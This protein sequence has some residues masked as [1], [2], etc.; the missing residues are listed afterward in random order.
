MQHFTKKLWSSVS[1][2]VLVTM[3]VAAVSSA[4]TV[5]SAN[6]YLTSLQASAAADHEVVFTTPSGVIE[7]ETV[8]LTFASAF[9]TSSITEDDVD[10]LDEAIELTTAADCSGSE[11]ASVVMA[12]DMLT[13][14]ICVGDGG[15]IAA[16]SEVTIRIGTN[17][18]SSG[19]GSNQITNPTSVGTYYVNVSGSFGDSGSIALPMLDA[20]SMTVTGR[21]TE[22]SG[23]GGG[24]GGGGASGCGD[25]TAP[26]ISSIVVSG[27][28]ADS[29]TVG[30]KSSENASGS[31]DYGTTS[32]YEIG[33]DEDT[34]LVT[35][36]SMELSSLSEGATYHFRVRSSDLCGNE[37]I[38]SD[39][40]FDTLDETAPEISD[41]DVSLSCDTTA[42]VSWSTDED[43]NST[44]SYGRTST[45]G[46]TKEDV[47][48]E[49][50]HSLV[51]SGLTRDATYHFQITSD[52]ES[53]NAAQTSDATFSADSDTAPSNVSGF[54][55]TAGDGT[56]ALSWTNPTTDVSGVRILACTGGYPDD[57]SDT[58][59]DVAYDGSGES[60]SHSGLSNGTTYYYG[61]FAY[62]TCGQFASGALGQGTPSAPEEEVL[63]IEEETPPVVTSPEETPAETG[64]EEGSA[65]EGVADASE[66]VPAGEESSEEVVA[67]VEIPEITVGDEER[68]PQGDMQFFVANRQIRL[69]TASSGAVGMLSSRPLR[70]EL[71]TEHISK[72]V[73]RVQLV[74]GESAYLMAL[75]SDESAY[76]TDISSPGSSGTYATA[77]SIYYADGT[78]QS[79][80]TITD[81]EPDG[82][83]FAVSDGQSRRVGGATISLSVN[84]AVTWDGSPYGQ[85][86][87]I[88]TESIGQL[89][90]YV[91]NTTYV[92][93]AAADG[94]I[95]AKTGTFSVTNNIANPVIQLEPTP[96]EVVPPT[97]ISEN[98]VTV[99][100]IVSDSIV[101]AVEALREVPGAE[102]ATT[103][104]IPVVAVIT[105]LAT[106]VL[107]TSFNLIPF[108]QYVFT[109]PFLF[110]WRRKRRA[111][112]IVYN[113]VTKLPIDLATIRLYRMPDDWQG[114]S[115]VVGR[116]I[117][118]RVTDKGGRYFFLPDLGRYRLV[119][120][121]NGFVFPSRYLSDEK[122]DGTFLDVYHAEPIEVTDKDA[123]IAANVP[124]DPSGEAKFHEPKAVV[125]V[126]RL[127]IAQQVVAV[128]GIVL[129]LI[130]AVI[131]PSVI[132]VSM[133]GVQIAF[134][135]LVRRLA[136]PQRPKSWG[137]VYD[138]ATGRPL[139]HAI[140]RVFEPKYNKL[141]ETAVTDSKGRYTFLLGPNE[142]YTVYEKEGFE[143]SVAHPIDYRT[144][145]EPKEFSADVP[146]APKEG[147]SSSQ[148]SSEMTQ[149]PTAPQPPPASV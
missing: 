22:N 21:V 66:E 67:P 12:A 64:V 98:P 37:T 129:S 94:Y 29:A 75:T 133:V 114:E 92:L 58:N 130:A 25:S 50:D 128:V 122:D 87:P 99:I 62:D 144:H 20:G 79:I 107:A 145:A 5:T 54:S 117:Q 124:L 90:W 63:P 35:S 52:D 123:V 88:M 49:T 113:A 111:F 91:P 65:E 71:L 86:N 109:S 146:L 44:V 112:G 2:I 13:V 42:T 93:S 120:S 149:P 74:I 69:S 41:V 11:Q 125:R 57:E 4:A 59:C 103:V 135:L 73:D 137:I 105:A 31:L 134:Y 8:T 32:S 53:G 40:T 26:T 136:A 24:G 34:S 6:D 23:G 95:S 56:S 82:Y 51:L 70:V 14:T 45:Y 77:V 47:A 119:A 132:S 3:L 142:Y 72:E 141:L 43:A 106:V 139:A 38:S 148:G 60:Y 100:S 19:T 97:S 1:A 108:L 118:S 27:V 7:G 17:A 76:A 9:D 68:V 96:A 131:Q 30:W 116:L 140:A 89:G 18:A 104:S 33:T 143:T 83:V 85:F 81:V 147:G 80:S 16:A 110:F 121:K 101:H 36:H 115:N 46:S 15:A 102:E 61:A 55:V 28:S 84:G 127:R 10:V 48:F 39:Q 78:T 138:K 126:R